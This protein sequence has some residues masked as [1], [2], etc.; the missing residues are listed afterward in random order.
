M[1]R[2]S[3]PRHSFLAATLVGLTLAG[4]QAAAQTAAE[5]GYQALLTVP[6]EPPILTEQQYFDLWQHWPEPERGRAAAATPEERRQ[7]MLERYGFQE[8]PDRPGP[9]PQQFTS[10]GKGHLSLNQQFSF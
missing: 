7:M 10:D 5:R 1:V 6:L 4:S 9:V 3:F 8:T 2:Y